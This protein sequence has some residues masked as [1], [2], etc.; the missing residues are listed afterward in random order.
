MHLHEEY[1]RRNK[2]DV[3]V[4][5]YSHKSRVFF[6]NKSAPYKW[7]ILTIFWH[8]P[9]RHPGFFEMKC[10]SA[11][12]DGYK[13]NKLVIDEI[14]SQWWH[15]DEYEKMLMKLIHWAKEKSLVA[16]ELREQILAAWQIFLIMYDSWLA[17]NM[18]LSFFKYVG[19]TLDPT[20][21]LDEREAACKQAQT[22]L[23][24][25]KEVY[26]GWTGQLLPLTKSRSEWLIRLIND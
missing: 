10:A 25:H 14:R 20:H 7:G 3:P 19:I 21:S 6:K 26:E 12:H 2:L 5:L 11:Q 9:D 15:W 8:E 24:G 13:D 23:S 22:K 17:E 18:D 16:L 1:I 4:I